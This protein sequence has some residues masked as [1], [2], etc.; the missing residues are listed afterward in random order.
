M[1]Y[2]IT[3]ACNGCGACQKICP[4]DAIDG[5]KKELHVI[6]EARCIECGSC[7]RICPQQ[8]VQDGFGIACETIKHSKWEKPVFDRKKCMSC[9]ICIDACPVKCLALSEAEAK[10]P[11]GYPYLEK[12]K[13]C[14]GCG[15]CAYECPVNAVTMAVPQSVS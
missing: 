11:H 6:D 15:F 2:R 9:T 10:D 13:I 3:D 4:V 7:G 12:E 1:A 14:L 5:E 8:A